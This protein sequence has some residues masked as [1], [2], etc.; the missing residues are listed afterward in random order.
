MKYGSLSQ[1]FTGVA[2]KRLSAVEA[3]PDTSNQHEFNG[4]NGLRLILGTERLAD[5]PARFVWLGAE[6]EGFTE[7]SLVTWYDSRLKNPKRSPEYRLYFRSNPVMEMAGAGDLLVVARRP[8]GELIIVVAAQGSTVENQLLWLFGLPAQEG[9]GFEVSE[10]ENGH[11]A[12]I[13]FA[14]RFILDELQIEIQEPDAEYLDTL[15]DRYRGRFPTTAEF[16]SFARDTVSDVSPGDDP[17]GALIAWLE[18]EE[19]LFRRLER[20][21]VSERLREGFMDGDG[22]DVDVDGFIKFSLSVQNRRKSRSGLALENHL[23]QVFVAQSVSYSRGAF[24]ENNAKP[25]FLFP[26]SAEY[27]DIDFPAS[28]LTMLGVKSTCKDRWRQVLSEAA[29]IPHKHLLT[30]EPGISVNQTEEMQAQNLQLVLPERLHDT[31]RP[32]QRAW[33]MDLAGFIDHVAAAQGG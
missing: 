22:A 31:Y 28:Q 2:T 3:D 10:I 13:D 1:Y 25:D 18:Q 7:D 14:A 9:M 33:L 12:Q 30:L 29:R 11:D 15:L 32:E 20:H 4:V 5:I 21:V 6:N 8:S 16:S 19:R 27:D 26:G 23:E 24:T 17:D